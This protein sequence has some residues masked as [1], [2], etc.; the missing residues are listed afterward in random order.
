MNKINDGAQMRVRIKGTS[1]E[2]VGVPLFSGEH[3]EVL[4]IY[5]QENRVTWPLSM[6]KIIDGEEDDERE[7]QMFCAIVTGHLGN[8]ET[9]ALRTM[10]NII[11]H[12]VAEAR[13]AIKMYNKAKE[14][15]L[16]KKE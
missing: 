2:I 9:T 6:I 13:E 3:G 1:T 11:Q 14:K 5:D 10:D 15:D 16:K 7:F 4:G 12:S 8:P